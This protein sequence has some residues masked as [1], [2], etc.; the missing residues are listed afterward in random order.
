[1][2]AFLY[3]SRGQREKIDP[4]IL[5]SRPQDVIQGDYAYW[6]EAFAE[7]YPASVC[8]TV[9]NCSL[10]ACRAWDSTVC[11]GKTRENRAKQPY[12]A[13]RRKWHFHAY[14][15]ICPEKEVNQIAD[16]G[17]TVNPHWA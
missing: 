3:A 2:A 16:N 12:P 4:R 7:H 9:L 13:S 17:L 6:T 15:Q 10:L 1:M 11:V 14:S 8:A 5:R